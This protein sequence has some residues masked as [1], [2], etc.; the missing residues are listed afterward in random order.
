MKAIVSPTGV[1]EAQHKEDHSRQQA[2]HGMHLVVGMR[3]RN[4]NTIY[5]RAVICVTTAVLSRFFILLALCCTL[6]VAAYR[7][8]FDPGHGGRDLIPHTLYGDKFD[9]RLGVYLDKFREGARYKGVWEFEVMHDIAA[10]AKAILDKT[11]TEAGRAEFKKIL[12]KYGKPQKEIEQIDAFV[13]RPAGYIENYFQNRDD[14]NAPFRLYDYPNQKTGVIEH[15]TISRINE[16]EPELVITLHLTHTHAPS[17]GGMATVITPGYKTYENALRYVRSDGNGRQAIR[18]R[19]GESAW[20][21]WF[22]SDDRFKVYPSFMADAFIYYIGFW[23]K[24]DGVRTDYTRFRGYRHN[25][26]D[27]SYADSDS[28]IESLYG[29]KGERYATT[30][31]AFEPK[32]KFWEREKAEPENWRREGGMEGFGGDNHYAGMEVLRFARK[33]FVVNGFDTP[34]TAP[35]LLKPYISTWAVPTYVNAIAA[36]VEIAHTTSRRD[37]LRM[38][39]HRRIYAEGIAVAAYSLLYGMS[40]TGMTKGKKLPLDRYENLAGGNYFKR[41]KKNA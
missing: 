39:K 36:F 34:A 14:V 17:Q 33:A 38:A 35:K 24:P 40:D 16:L 8:V 3:R 5:R 10:K 41:V 4:P 19:F 13:S 28:I 27:W 7:V 23:S 21:N 11:T 12:K 18:A 29:Q 31:S 37:H 32:G 15:G 25:L 26:V 22:V 2:A 20:A 1:D 30:L 9:R 6:P